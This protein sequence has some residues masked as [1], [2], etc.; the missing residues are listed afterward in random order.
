MRTKNIL[1]L[2]LLPIFTQVYA[3]ANSISITNIKLGPLTSDPKDKF[4]VTMK[5]TNN[6]TTI[7]DWELGFYMPRTFRVTSTANTQLKMEICTI[8]RHPKCSTLNYL[9]NSFIESDL[10]TVFTTILAPSTS[11]PLQKHHTYQIR[12]IHNTARGALNYSAFP[13]S[14]FVINGD[15]IINIYTKPADYTVVGKYT[16]QE[17]TQNVQKHINDEWLNSNL[18]TTPLNVIPAPQQVIINESGS[19]DIRDNLIIHNNSKISP[20]TLAFWQLNLATDLDSQIMID[21]KSKATGITLEQ[22]NTKDMPNPESYKIIIKK[23]QLIVQASNDAG[24]FYA[25]QTLRQLWQESQ[26]LPLAT[27]IDAPRF[28]YRGVMLDVARHYFTPNEIKHLIDIMAATK[29]NTLHLHLSDNEAFRLQ[30]TNYPELTT[31]GASRG[32]GEKIGPMAMIQHNLSKAAYNLPPTVNYSGSYSTEEIKSLIHY[33]NT[34]QITIIPELDIP[35]HSRALMKALP[36]IFYESQDISEYSGFGDNSIPVCAYND[37]S[38]FG[39][40]FTTTLNDIIEQ[41]A[42]LFSEQTTV[43]AIN[44]EINIGG[45]EVSAHTWDKSPLCESKDQWR[46]LTSSQKEHYFL[47]QLAKTMAQK[48][49][50]FSGWH[51]SIIDDDDNLLDGNSILPINVGHVYAWGEYKKT[52]PKALTLINNRYPTVLSYADGLYFDMKYTQQLDEPGF[53]WATQYGDTYAALNSA[54][55]ASETQESATNAKYILGL[56][57]GI[58]T[59]VIPDYYQL[60]YMALPKLAGLAEAAWANSE[61]TTESGIPNWHSLAVRLGCGKDGFLAYL[62]RN[63]KINYRGKPNGIS[64]EAPLNCSFK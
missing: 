39:R 41:T 10:S 25:L 63:Y 58:W 49:I 30:L 12:L 64:K 22:L 33:A 48:D 9:K 42:N 60:Q 37:D 5:I 61:L 28:Q 23:Q 40:K 52:K 7:N 19:F 46:N 43:Y 51:E 32:L 16:S 15:K 18:T 59:D 36:H 3:G 4:S 38:E 31:I 62:D 8:Q 29:L 57:A 11:F 14:F 27:I 35:G 24:F 56:E 20:E 53:Y 6:A 47:G 13:Q 45:D 17:I 2:I 21:S 55:Q 1:L 44:N 50:H 34:R 26:L 54:I